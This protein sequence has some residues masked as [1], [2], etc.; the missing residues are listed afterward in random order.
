MPGHKFDSVEADIT[1]KKFRPTKQGAKK[2]E[3]NL[4]TL[5]ENESRLLKSVKS[6]SR[7]KDSLKKVKM[8]DKL[9]KK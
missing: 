1:L 7:K 3:E 8:N 4:F 9:K 6:L 5:V 2:N